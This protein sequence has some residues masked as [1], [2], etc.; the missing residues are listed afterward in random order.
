MTDKTLIEA[1]EQVLANLE[2]GKYLDCSGYVLGML[3][4]QGT[5][6]SINKKRGN[7]RIIWGLVAKELL[8][9]RLSIK[10]L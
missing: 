9:Q 5:Q 1:M 7:R 2:A 10:M 8:R 4:G 6:V 3:Y